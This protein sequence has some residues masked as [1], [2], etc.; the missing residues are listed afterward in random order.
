MSLIGEDDVRLEPLAH[1]EIV[2]DSCWLA[3]NKFLDTCPTCEF[4]EMGDS[5]G[6]ED[7]LIRGV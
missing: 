2:C 6:R 4:Y 3:R 7:L 1:W 5:S